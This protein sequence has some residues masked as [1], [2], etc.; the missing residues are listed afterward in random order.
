MPTSWLKTR[1]KEWVHRVKEKDFAYWARLLITVAVVQSLVP[2]ADNHGLITDSRY[3]FY[4][5]LQRLD[6]HKSWD[7]NT[8]VITIDDDEYYKGPLQGRIPIK[9]DYLACLIEKLDGAEAK[10]IALDFDLRSPSPDGN[11]VE[12]PDYADETSQ[13]LQTIKQVAARRLIVLPRTIWKQ[14]GEY[15]TNSDIYDGFDF[16]S[17]NVFKGY[18]ALPYERL[19]IPL[20]LKLKGNVPLDS[21][22]MAIVRA[23]R[24]K[25]LDYLPQA[26]HAPY[27]SF[28]TEAAFDH[29]TAHEVLTA[30]PKALHDELSGRIIIIGAA[31]R[32]WAF[33]TGPRIDLHPTPMGS[34]PGAYL[35]ANYVEAILDTRTYPPFG[36]RVV[37]AVEWL[38]VLAMA[39]GFAATETPAWKILVV[40]VS[41][42]VLVL[43]TYFSFINLG[44]VFD[45]FVPAISVTVHWVFEHF[46][47]GFQRKTATT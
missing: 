45:L 6:R 30:D 38:V 32:K 33:G 41:W 31:W 10:V 20:T 3:A 9:R 1:A 28:I 4:R 26:D 39:L 37:K 23:F 25:A 40:V 17:T 12:S 14:N 42:L 24:S 19:E 27:A 8:V 2:W 7:Q 47:E 16:A 22:S 5:L 44:H 15:V 46:Y 21:F 43:F 36:V 29:K 13:L 34:M 11:P 35:H 18:I